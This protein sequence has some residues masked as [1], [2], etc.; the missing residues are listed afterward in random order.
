MVATI[1]YFCE[2]TSLHGVPEI[3]RAKTHVGRILW[4]ILFILM[5]FVTGLFI[6]LVLVAYL[7]APIVTTIYQAHNQSLMLP[8]IAVCYTAFVN[9]KKLLNEGLSWE[10]VQH[11]SL[12]FQL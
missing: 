4:L 2:T 1:G 7:E 5:I 3:Y 8:E 9:A 10:A 6:Y 11:L 12:I